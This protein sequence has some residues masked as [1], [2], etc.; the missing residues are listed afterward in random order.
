MLE[1]NQHNDARKEDGE[2]ELRSSVMWRKERKKGKV[3]ESEN[4]NNKQVKTKQKM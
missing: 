3:K 4:K 2:P 1:K